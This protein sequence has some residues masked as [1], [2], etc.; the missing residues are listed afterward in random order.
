MERNQ[1][2]GLVGREEFSGSIVKRKKDKRGR[3]INISFN[4]NP[5]G[6]C[7]LAGKITPTDQESKM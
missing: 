6:I 5:E 4:S 7:I 2:T 1:R 3:N